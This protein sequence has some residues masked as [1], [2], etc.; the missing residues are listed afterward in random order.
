MSFILDALKKS[1]SDRQRQSGPSLFEVKVAPP[2]RALPVWAVA[3]AVLLGVNVIVVSWMLLRRPATQQTQQAKQAQ[4]APQP[5]AGNAPAAVPPAATLTPAASQGTA[6]MSAAAGP[7]ARPAGSTRPAA[8]ADVTPAAPAS[9]AEAPAARAESS[10]QPGQ[11]SSPAGGNDQNAGP[12][13]SGGDPSDYA[14]AVE[15]AGAQAP[16]TASGAGGLPLYQQIVT[17]DGLPELHLDLHVFAARPHDRFVMINMHRLG[18]GDSLP[19][20]VQVDAI[21]PDGVVLTYHGTRFLLPRN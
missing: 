17:S 13:Q 18:E 14:P 2:R 5:A 15:P 7:S 8:S 3:I 19:G 1:E 12:A 6:Q 16:G 9:A 20:G 10:S 4:P 11:E 21:R